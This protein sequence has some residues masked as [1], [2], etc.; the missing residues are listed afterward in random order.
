MDTLGL[1]FCA[2]RRS[3]AGVYRKRA[4]GV[5]RGCLICLPYMCALYVCLIC[6]PQEGI[7]SVQT[8]NTYYRMCSLTYYR[9]CS[10]TYY[11]MC[12]LTSRGHQECAD[13]QHPCAFSVP[14]KMLFHAPR[15]QLVSQC[16]VSH[17]QHACHIINKHVTS[18]YPTRVVN[19]SGSALAY[20]VILCP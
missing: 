14:Q 19:T 15:F 8:V 18:S 17:H 7:R 12:S 3:H 4:S 2:C 20:L 16:L 1:A 9:M 13:R 10:L 11:R 6:M 5:C